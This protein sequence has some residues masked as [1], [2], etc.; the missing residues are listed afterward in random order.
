MFLHLWKVVQA[1]NFIS[2]KFRFI[3]L[4][5]EGGPKT[6]LTATKACLRTPNSRDFSGH[7]FIVQIL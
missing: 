4:A 6:I 2:P 5:V 7:K 3:N 1:G